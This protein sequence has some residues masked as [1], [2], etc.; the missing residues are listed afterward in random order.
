MKELMRDPE[1]ISVDNAHTRRTPLVSNIFENLNLLNAILDRHQATIF[2]RWDKKSEEKRRSLVVA[3][4]GSRMAENRRP[5][6]KVWQSVLAQEYIPPNYREAIM[7]PHINQENLVKGSIL[8]LYLTT[9]AK[10]HPSNFVGAD[11]KAMHMKIF[12]PL[13]GVTQV[14]DYVMKFTERDGPEEYAE[15]LRIRDHPQADDWLDSEKAWPV[16]WSLLILEAQETIMS[17]LVKCAKAVLHDLSHQ[18]L[19]EGPSHSIPMPAPTSATGLHRWLIWS[20]NIHTALRRLST[21]PRSHPCLMRST[22]MPSITWLCFVRTM[23]TSR[24]T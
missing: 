9:R 22:A 14:T 7:M 4:W 24:D 15:I 5:D 17:F 18:Q 2:K 12:G 3:A 16:G 20:A 13:L 23:D 8:P 19:V 10:T 1:K 11:C 21:S 6:F